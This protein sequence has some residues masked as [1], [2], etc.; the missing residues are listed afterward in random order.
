M[1]YAEDHICS[2]R[3]EFADSD[4]LSI[5]AQELIARQKNEI[6]MM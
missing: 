6:K 5:S 1:S 2:V 3:E 4:D